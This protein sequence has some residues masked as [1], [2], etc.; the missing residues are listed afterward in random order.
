MQMSHMDRRALNVVESTV[1]VFFFSVSRMEEEQL[2]NVS[3]IIFGE[4]VDMMCVLL[5]RDLKP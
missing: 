2:A 4:I 1:G 5:R 3:K